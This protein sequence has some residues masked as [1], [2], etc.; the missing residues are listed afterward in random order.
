MVKNTTLPS[1]TLKKKHNAIA[2]H[3]ICEAVAA[4]IVK[5]AYIR[6]KENRADILTKALSPQD[7]YYLTIDI[8]FTRNNSGNQG[9]LQL[10]SSSDEE[11]M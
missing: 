6:S 10:G 8:L 5:I 4:G 2:Y 7:H 11:G 3:K 1:S 9:E